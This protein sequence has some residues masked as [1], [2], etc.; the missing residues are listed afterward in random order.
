MISVTKCS[1]WQ[2]NPNG[3]CP[4]SIDRGHIVF[5]LSTTL[6]LAMSF[7]LYD[8]DF[9]YVALSNDIKADDFV[10]LTLII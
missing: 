2:N 7:E 8:I 6:T 1:G 10:T 9:T 3:L 5:F 4:A